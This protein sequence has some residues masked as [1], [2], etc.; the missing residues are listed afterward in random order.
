[1]PKLLNN[2]YFRQD[3]CPRR[4]GPPATGRR[5]E[6]GLLQVG[7]G[8]G[9][10]G[11]G[12]VEVGAGGHGEIVRIA[13]QHGRGIGPDV[14]GD[15]LATEA[16]DIG[17]GETAGQHLV[18]IGVEQ[19]A[20]NDRPLLVQA[21]GVQHHRRAA[22]RSGRRF[23]RGP[24]KLRTRS[25]PPRMNRPAP[26]A[27]GPRARQYRSAPRWRARSWRASAPVRC[28]RRPP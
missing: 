14:L 21:L 5:P 1:M 10:A 28:A 15:G 8:V 23:G 6:L 19:L 12:A 11:D 26:W 3:P 24:W 17:V 7:A 2:P 13:V 18:L 9:L 4:T 20:Q 16:G 22:R 25:A 27:T